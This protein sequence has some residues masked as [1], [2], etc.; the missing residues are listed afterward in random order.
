LVVLGLALLGARGSAQTVTVQRTLPPA[1][2]NPSASVL[3]VTGTPKTL[4]PGVRV[5]NLDAGDYVAGLTLWEL[6]GVTYL[7]TYLGFRWTPSAGTTVFTVAPAIYFNDNIQL[8]AEI[9]DDG[10]VVGTNLFTASLNS[11]P[12]RWTEAEGFHYL[13]V[14][15]PGGSGSAVATSS[16]A[17]TIVGGV[18]GPGP[19]TASR[20]ARWVDLALEVIGAP[21]G[22]SVA[23]DVSA[24]GA[25]TVGESGPT[26]VVLHATRWFG[27]FEVGLELVPGATSSR[28]RF[29]SAD[30][31]VTVGWATLANGEQRL[32]RW[33]VDGSARVHTVPPGYVLEGVAAINPTATAIVGSVSDGVPFQE[34]HTPFVWRLG[35]G[36]TIIDE[37]G[38]GDVYNASYAIDVSDDGECV[39][40]KLALKVTTGGSPPSIAFL[41]TPDGTRDVQQML[42]ASGGPQLYLH[43]PTAISGDGRRLLV[44]GAVRPRPS[45]TAAVLL[46]FDLGPPLK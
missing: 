32:V 34:N 29:V 2:G 46:E 40:G 12:F 3:E 38:M 10:T 20:A 15:T 4:Q 45:D 35:K 31:N 14:E 8:P 44:T 27:G 17:T 33:L 21:G 1:V 16:D 28:A 22:A 26:P 19:F 39:V 30:G 5:A 37:L 42:T 41:W 7:E 18:R 24:D 11:L 25:V 13:P 36:F 6:Q 9:A 43:T 23:Y